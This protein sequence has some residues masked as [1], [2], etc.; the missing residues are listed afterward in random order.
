MY[1]VENGIRISGTGL[2]LDATKK[3]PFSFISHAH[4]DHVRQHKH[5]LATPQTISL[6]KIKTRIGRSTQLAFREE[7]NLDGLTIELLPAGHI[8]GSAQILVRRENICLLY[9]GDFSTENNVTA[10]QCEIRQADILIMESTFGAPQYIF[11]PKWIIIEKL[12]LFIDSCFNKG[13]IPIILGYGIGKAQEA[14]KILGDLDYQVSVH[15]SIIPVIKIYEKFGVQFKNYQAY[16]GEDLR[17]RVLIIP[18]Q[19]SR[20]HLVKQI[21]NAKKLML[22]GWAIMP[23]AKFRYGADE[24]LPF[25]DH[26]D[27]NQ[28]IEYVHKVNPRR[29]FIT[30]GFNQFVHDLRREG[31]IAELLQ[32]NPQRSLF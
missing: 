26:A 2:W 11:P 17:N 28:L 22:T 8:L 18:P 5:I 23:Q 12:V 19:F 1:D 29:V 6:I 16:Q 3:V 20:G 4:S 9:S 31:F 10:A 24:A 7:Y 30:H 21:V 14:L 13:L 15:P 25:S 32:E 27:Y